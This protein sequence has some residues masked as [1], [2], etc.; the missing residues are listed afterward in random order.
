MCARPHT[1]IPIPTPPCRQCAH[2]RSRLHAYTRTTVTPP[3]R[4]STH[5]HTSARGRMHAHTFL[6]HGHILTH[7][8]T[9]TQSYMCMLVKLA[10]P[11]CNC[12][13]LS[14]MRPQRRS[15]DDLKLTLGPCRS[16]RER[17]DLSPHFA[18]PPALDVFDS[19][20]RSCRR[21]PSSSRY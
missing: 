17:V 12:L 14:L 18:H 19:L 5:T 1:R 10:L 2:T 7:Q 21:A 20:R 6:K 9:N 16:T 4:T 13:Q 15:W 8:N 3:P 11:Q